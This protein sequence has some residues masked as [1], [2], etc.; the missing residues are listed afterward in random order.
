MANYSRRDM[1]THGYY[2]RLVKPSSKQMRIHCS[3]CD[4][5][6]RNACQTTCCGEGF[7]QECLEHLIN[8][9]APCPACQAVGYHGYDDDTL[10]KEIKKMEVH[11]EHQDEGCQWVGT[12]KKLKS[13]LNPYNMDDSK[14]CGWIMV[15]CHLCS[16]EVARNVLQR[17]LSES[18]M[19]RR[20]QCQYCGD[21]KST[22]EDVKNNHRPVC[23]F[24]PVA[25]PNE[26]GES[27]MQLDLQSHVTN[28]CPLKFI[29]CEYK[30]F[31]CNMKIQRQSYPQHIQ[32]RSAQV[33]S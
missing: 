18:C 26:C 12:I 33:E 17:H 29:S 6:L 14:T 10:Q 2:C 32:E 21:F 31:G 1:K 28:D 16:K 19:Q 22:Y 7:C 30:V 4:G 3:L 8:S 11:C 13:H 25:C 5:I 20:Y 24:T 27:V 15:P 9:H 23:K